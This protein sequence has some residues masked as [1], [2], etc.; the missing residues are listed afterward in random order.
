MYRQSE[1][2]GYLSLNY[3][4][5][6]LEM[7]Y[8]HPDFH[9]RGYGKKLLD[10]AKEKCINWPQ[11]TLQASRNAIPFYQSSGFMLQHGESLCRSSGT[12]CTTM[13]YKP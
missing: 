12:L 13:I 1:P 3:A 6:H 9:G 10:F 2:I 5:E 7:L 11:I 8:I 4:K